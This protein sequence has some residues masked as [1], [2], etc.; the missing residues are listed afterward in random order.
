MMCCIWCTFLSSGQSNFS[1][2]STRV[3]LA[4]SG[5]AHKS[6]NQYNYQSLK[7]VAASVIPFMLMQVEGLMVF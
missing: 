7:P 6:W 5:L 3:T 4:I 1:P 2:Y